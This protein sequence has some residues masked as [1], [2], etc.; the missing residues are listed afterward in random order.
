MFRSTI[1]LTPARPPVPDEPF[2]FDPDVHDIKTLTGGI[3]RDLIRGKHVTFAMI[4]F[5]RDVPSE[6]VLMDVVWK[7]PALTDALDTGRPAQ[8]IFYDQ[9]GLILTLTFEP[10]GADVLVTG[11]NPTGEFIPRGSTPPAMRVPRAVIAAEL[12]KV[13][14]DVLAAGTAIGSEFADHPL[15]KQWAERVKVIPPD[16]V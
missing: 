13:A 15:V 5:G 14:G 12:R 10:A 7:L 1:H 8:L 4:L 11:D 6:E 16:A 3:V 9:G 2:V